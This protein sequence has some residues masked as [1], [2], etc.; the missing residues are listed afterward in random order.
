MFVHVKLD[1][2]DLQRCI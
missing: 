1:G 2:I